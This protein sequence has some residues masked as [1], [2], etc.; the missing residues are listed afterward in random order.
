MQLV[1]NT[2]IEAQAMLNVLLIAHVSFTYKCENCVSSRQNL[3]VIF[4]ILTE[5]TASCAK[6]VFIVSDF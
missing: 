1:C 4:K 2:S 3:F 5:K 6:K